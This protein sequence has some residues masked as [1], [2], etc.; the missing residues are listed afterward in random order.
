MIQPKNDLRGKKFGRLTPV[1]YRVKKGGHN[2]WLCVCDCGMTTLVQGSDLT[3]GRTQSCGCLKRERTAECNQELK[4]KHGESGGHGKKRTRL[5]VIWM[6]MLQRCEN[7]T[8]EHDRRHYS[9]KGI[10]VCEAW[11]DFTN[12]KQWAVDNGY[13]D[14][15]GTRAE[16]LSIDRI[17][18]DGGYNPENCRWITL[19]QN[20]KRAR[21][22]NQR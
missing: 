7:P 20:C 19:G 22:A 18:P 1:E 8:H 13:V 12:F 4:T 11:H 5:Y 21:Q 15:D 17:D 2:K 16:R 3:S 6:G 9:T 10:S 14:I